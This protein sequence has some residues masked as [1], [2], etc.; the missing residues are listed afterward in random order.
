[1]EVALVLAEQGQLAGGA[2]DQERDGVGPG[3]GERRDGIGQ[4]GT[5]GDEGDAGAAGGAGVAV[6]HVGG[7]LLVAGGKADDGV[8]VVDGIVD[9]QVVDARDTEGVTDPRAHE[10]INDQ[11]TACPCHPV[12]SF[13]LAV[14]ASPPGPLLQIVE[15]GEYVRRVSE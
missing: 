3:A 15:Q 14:H 10:R 11:L 5:G 8:L 2:D 6:G 4:A 1:M 7:A 13:V 9:G 12:L